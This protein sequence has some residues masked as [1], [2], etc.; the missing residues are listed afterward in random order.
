[1]VPG[2]EVITMSDG[3]HDPDEDG[4]VMPPETDEDGVDTYDDDEDS[5]TMPPVYH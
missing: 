3:H 2:K 1:M 4:V 5:G